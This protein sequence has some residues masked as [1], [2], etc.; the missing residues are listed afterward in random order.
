MGIRWRAPKL[1][2]LPAFLC[3]FAIASLGSVLNSAARTDDAP[4][5]PGILAT[6][7]HDRTIQ[8]TRLCLRAEHART[9][10]TL[11]SA[12]IV[13]TAGQV[14]RTRAGRN[15]LF[16]RYRARSLDPVHVESG[17]SPPLS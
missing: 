5:S 7:G 2:R 11:R 12:C 16:E 15:D 6:A 8:V 13:A 17:R 3:A 1:T 10:T 14:L 4:R 9:R